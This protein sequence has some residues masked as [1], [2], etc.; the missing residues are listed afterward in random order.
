MDREY[1]MIQKYLV[2]VR[3]NLHQIPELGTHLP[4]TQKYVCEELK[5][6]GIPYWCSEKDSG[7]IAEIRGRYEGKTVA[8]RADMD[9]LPLQ[10][11]NTVSYRSRH[12]GCMHACGHD[13]H[14]AI[15]LGAAKILQ[16]ERDGMHGNVRLIFQ[17]AEEI[18]R[19]SEIAISNGC[20]KDVAAIFGLHIG[21]I[22]G[23][24]I[25]TGTL[26]FPRACC[27]ASFDKFIICVKGQSCHGSTPEKGVDPVNIAAH[28]LIALQ[29]IQTR[30]ISGTASSVIT[31]GKITGGTQY[32][33]IPDQ[34]VLEGTIRALDETV[35]Q[36]IA[37]RIKELA[38]AISA[39]FGGSCECEII[40]GAP[41][42]VN[43]ETMAELAAKAVSDLFEPKDIIEDFSIPNMGGEDFANYLLEV[44]GAFFFLSSSN[45][46]KGTDI[47]H[48][49]P[50][51]N[52][53]EDVMWKGTVTFVRIVHNMLQIEKK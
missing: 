21:N 1:E 25:P 11:Q 35:R 44:L 29:T 42:V 38:V 19:G 22:L 2:K 3:R 15:L 51:F 5:K 18:S 40:W 34:V 46:K 31:V 24:E 50:T 9:A 41:P 4:K 10:E 12:E 33:V 13:A 20:L 26:I 49:N 32:N 8:L 36:Y 17:T 52:I 47:P 37:R 27:M 28:L 39:M 7:I 23:K 43:D 16:E 14:M 53:D 45:E 48:H 6:M 30:E